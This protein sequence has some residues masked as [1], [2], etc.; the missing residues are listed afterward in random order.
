MC[1]IKNKKKFV[2]VGLQN[3]VKKNEKI[4]FKLFYRNTKK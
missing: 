4:F 3:K 1:K 2:C